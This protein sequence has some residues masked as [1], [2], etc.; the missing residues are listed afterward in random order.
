MLT[1]AVGGQHVIEAA[2]T[3]VVAPAVAADDP[4][5]LLDQLVGNRQ[6]IASRGRLVVRQLFFQRLHAL[7]LGEDAFL[8]R[9]IGTQNG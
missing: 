1:L 5:A 4:D 6:Q 9:L 8:G 2:V 7:A 3:D